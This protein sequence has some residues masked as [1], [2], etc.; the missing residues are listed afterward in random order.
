MTSR[1][2][3]L[4]ALDH[5]TPDRTPFAWG[6]GPTKPM[7]GT[8]T[9]WLAERGIDWLKLRDAVTDTLVLEP[10][11]IGPP[12]KP[13]QPVYVGMWGI[14]TRTASY[15][16]GSYEEFCGHPLAGVSDPKALE[17]VPWPSAEW[18][19]YAA[20]PARV[21]DTTKAIQL[22]VGSSGN[23][24]EIY[25][26]MTGMEE[27]M[28][29]LVMNP[30]LVRAALDCICSYFETK[31]EGCVAALDGKI[32]LLH[33]ADDL[34]GQEG[35]LFSPAT[36][37]DVVQPFHARLIAHSKKVVPQAK[38]MYHSDGAVYEIMPDL[39]EAGVDVLEAV[40]TDATGMEP[41]RL[42]KAYGDHICFHGGIPVQSL[43]PHGSVDDVRR[44]CRRLC[45]VLGEHGGYIAAPTHAIQAGT[46][47]EN[48]W[49]MLE[50]VVG[51]WRDFQSPL[52]GNRV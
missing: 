39:I 6:F 35:L 17:D 4:T 5:R 36:Y 26:W 31:L 51:V 1:E 45:E 10:P 27:T 42:K 3:V 20:L 7:A 29:N 46:P 13:G 37:R 12:M 18:F 23:P 44:G 33:F 40:Q 32:D 22:A 2:R 9:T 15:G 30:E 28:I 52:D 25:T 21:Q 24:L 38:A 41:E 43:L 47:P 19:D 49:A 50:E 34:G 16:A 48:V 8:L 14:T 11:Y